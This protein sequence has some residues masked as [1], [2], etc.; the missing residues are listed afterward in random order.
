MLEFGLEVVEDGLC[1]VNGF[2]RDCHVA[3][4]WLGLERGA[5]LRLL[6]IQQANHVVDV[7]LAADENSMAGLQVAFMGVQQPE[8]LLGDF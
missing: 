1:P 7:R 4:D 8:L 2:G 5:V 3:R 6:F